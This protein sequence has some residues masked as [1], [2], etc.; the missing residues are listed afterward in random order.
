[1]QSLTDKAMP[2]ISKKVSVRDKVPW[3]NKAIFDQRKIVRNRERKWI[4]YS[5]DHQWTA[6]KRERNRYKNMINY[7]KQSVLS[8][9]IKKAKG[10][11]RSLYSVLNNMTENKKENPMPPDVDEETLCEE[12]ADY[13]LSKIENIR[14]LFRDVEPND[15][16]QTEVPLLR[17]FSCLTVSEVRDV[18]MSMKTKTCELDP[19]PTHLIKEKLSLFLPAITKIVNLSLDRGEFDQTWKNALVKPLLKKSGLALTHKN[20]R[21]VS[22][23]QFI[24][25][26]IEKA[27]LQQFLKHSEGII[28]DYQ[29]AYRKDAGCESV[30]QKLSNEILW[31]ME[32]QECLAISLLDLSAAFDTVDHELLLCVLK[33][34]Y[35]IRDLA[36]QWYDSYLRP[37]TFTVAINDK[38]SA[39]RNLEFFCSPRQ[40]QRSQYFYSLLPLA[41]N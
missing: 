37:R 36:L 23:L 34:T 8:S 10:D 4:K 39:P 12:F 24:S 26:V 28:P 31:A 5:E 11:T 20:Y 19:M 27:V 13:F 18:V 1:M 21:P 7:Y 29:S 9:K 32:N 16:P 38:K 41:Y 17:R 30:L 22:N 25:K 6:Y 14:Q 2:L 35:G 3:F 15:P 40:F 33:Q